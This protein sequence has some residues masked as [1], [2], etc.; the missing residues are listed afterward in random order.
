MTRDEGSRFSPRFLRVW[1][2]ARFEITPLGRAML[3]AAERDEVDLTARRR[4][5]DS[6]DD[7][8]A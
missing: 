5:Q 7:E 3:E 8:S 2:N 1:L 6:E 4:A